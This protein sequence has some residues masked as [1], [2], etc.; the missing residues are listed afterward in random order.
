VAYGDIHGPEIAHFEPPVDFAKKTAADLGRAQHV[1]IVDCVFE[2]FFDGLVGD[3]THDV[4]VHDTTFRHTWDDAWQMYGNVYHVDFHHN[5]CDGAGPS[6]DH[7]SPMRPT[8]RQEQ[9]SS[10]TRLCRCAK[11]WRERSGGGRG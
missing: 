4:E 11:Q 10:T 9:F 7:T 1:E 3:A 2:Q 8:P 5:M 6:M